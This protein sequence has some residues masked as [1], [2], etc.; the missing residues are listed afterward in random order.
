MESEKHRPVDLLPPPPRRA[1][2]ARPP[3]GGDHVVLPCAGRAS[4]GLLMT[5]VPEAQPPEAPVLEKLS[6]LDRFLPLWIGAAMALGIVLGKVLP[7]LD[8]TSTESKIDTVSLPIA[9]G[10]LVMMYPVLAKVR[11]SEPRRGHCRPAHARPLAGRSTL[12]DRP[13]ADV[14][15]GLAAAPRPAA[16]TGPDLD[17]RR[18]WPA[19]SP[20][21]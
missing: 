4:A 21:S 9:F 16:S 15:P 10:L 14:H 17:H 20:W 2:P 11:Y 6:T 8:D 18:R 13:G 19:A 3:A 5:A 12:G 7:G 1:R